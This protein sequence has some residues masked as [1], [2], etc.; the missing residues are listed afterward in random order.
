MTPN[1]ELSRFL[2]IVWER[3]LLTAYSAAAFVACPTYTFSSFI[4]RAALCDL[5]SG[6]SWL[7]YSTL[8][9]STQACLANTAWVWGTTKVM[10]LISAVPKISGDMLLRAAKWLLSRS[11]FVNGNRAWLELVR[12]N[13]RIFYGFAFNR[14]TISLQLKLIVVIV[15]KLDLSDWNIHR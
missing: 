10:F 13:Y 3:C 8:S 4:Q 9:S 6:G 15:Q 11:I 12:S 5:S 1:V 14:F 7:S 2:E